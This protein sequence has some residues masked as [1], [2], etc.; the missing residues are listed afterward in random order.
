MTAGRRGATL[1]ALLHALLSGL[2][3]FGNLSGTL[4]P[5]A[6]AGTSLLLFFAA[7]RYLTQ[8]AQAATS[9]VTAIPDWNDTSRN[10]P[11]N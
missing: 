4:Q 10:G 3:V 6:I 8:Q 1:L 11:P 2:V 9:T 7:R 5:W